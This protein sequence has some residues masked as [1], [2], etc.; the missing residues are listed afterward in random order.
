MWFE[1]LILKMK[2]EFQNPIQYFLTL[3]NEFISMNQL[4]GKKI[5]VKSLYTVCLECHKQKDLYRQGFCKSCFFESPR[6]GDWI[7]RPEKS[8]AHIKEKDRDLDYE[9]EIQ[10]Q[11]HIVYLAISGNIKVGVTRKEQI[12]TRWIDQGASEAIAVLEMPNRYLAGLAE[13]EMKKRISDRADFRK[14]LTN[15]VVKENLVDKKNELLPHLPESLR[16]YSIQ[17]E[18]IWKFSYPVVSFPNKID[19]VLNFSKIASFEK[20]LIG[21]K[22]QYLLFDDQTIFNLRANEGHYINL[23][24][25]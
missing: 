10:I 13:V 4:I 1:G 21:M 24:I 15:K 5:A 9:I 23:I 7:F 2:T 19:S 17:E 18:I 22:G 14:I 25:S 8:K 16:N 11:P 12:P 6:A 20:K 3:G